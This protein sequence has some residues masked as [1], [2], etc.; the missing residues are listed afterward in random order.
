VVLSEGDLSE[1]RHSEF[2]TLHPR[3][4]LQLTCRRLVQLN[5]VDLPQ[6]TASFFFGRLSP[7]FNTIRF[8]LPVEFQLR[9]S[10][11]DLLFRTL[12]R[13]LVKRIRQLNHFITDQDALSKLAR[14]RH[15]FS[16]FEVLL[17]VS[18]RCE[19]KGASVLGGDSPHLRKS[20]LSHQ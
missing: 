5:L 2:G 20:L 13:L 8:I 4:L 16:F 9:H 19:V 11:Y 6:E 14:R 1:T 7:C 18:E 15:L 12:G 3:C 17:L 10:S